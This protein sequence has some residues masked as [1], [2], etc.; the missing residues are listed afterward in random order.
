LVRVP[1]YGANGYS[2]GI[3][4]LLGLHDTFGDASEMVEAVP[5]TKRCGT[6]KSLKIGYLWIL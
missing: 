4:N 3:I 1:S 5:I 6:G 2:E